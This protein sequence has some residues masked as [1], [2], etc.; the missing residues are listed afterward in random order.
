M[1][2][3]IRHGS[4]ARPPRLQRAVQLFQ[5]PVPAGDL[6]I[7]CDLATDHLL[8]FSRNHGKLFLISLNGLSG[9]REDSFSFASGVGASIDWWN[10]ALPVREDL[11][12]T[13]NVTIEL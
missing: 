6:L 2:E 11:S 12:R 1:N 8:E 13:S 3:P 7:N 5:T 9:S 4:A 10:T